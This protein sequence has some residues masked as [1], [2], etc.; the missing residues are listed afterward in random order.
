MIEK[1]NKNKIT[2]DWLNLF[3]V[4]SSYKCNTYVFV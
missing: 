2:T 1:L 3:P 4:D